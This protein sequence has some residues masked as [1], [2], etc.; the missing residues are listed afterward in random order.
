MTWNKEIENGV[1]TVYLYGS[2]DSESAEQA[3]SEIGKA[4]SGAQQLVLDLKELRYVSSAVL[5]LILK[6]SK[7]MKKK[8]GVTVSNANESM[9]DVFRL[10]G[11]TDIMR[12]D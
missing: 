5:R 4:A 8:G 7:K 12:I 10:T 2:P 1:L 9:M 6:L 3:L 11:F